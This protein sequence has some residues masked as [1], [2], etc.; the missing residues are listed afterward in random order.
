MAPT[1]AVDAEEEKEGEEDAGGAFG[2]APVAP[3]R[4]QLMRPQTARRRPP[5]VKE[6]AE[7][8]APSIP[9]SGA[10]PQGLMREGEVGDEEEDEQGPE[11]GLGAGGALGAGA[12]GVS[13]VVGRG[14]HTRDILRQ[15]EEARRKAGGEEKEEA[16]AGGIRLGRI[17]R[18]KQE[19]TGGTLDLNELQEVIQRLCQSTHPLGQSMVSQRRS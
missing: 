19:A 11:G 17:R 18:R 4:A 2:S 1:H 12:G 9:T 16:G 15:Q 7:A 5:R 6:A 14:R 13:G 8:A 3:A 10:A